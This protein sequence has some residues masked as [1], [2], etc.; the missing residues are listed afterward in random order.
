MFFF[1]LKPQTSATQ[2]QFQAPVSQM[3]F[4]QQQNQFNRVP[5]Q[6][7]PSQGPTRFQRPSNIAPV[8]SMGSYSPFSGQPF[9]P[10]GL[11]G[12][13]GVRGF[14]TTGIHI[15]RGLIG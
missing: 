8:Q 3:S 12:L 14:V 9:G 13:P 1:I 2:S 11:S 6:Q 15:P 7:M 10:V 4:Q 5:Q